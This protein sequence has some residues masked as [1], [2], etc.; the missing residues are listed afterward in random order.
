M[1]TRA[2]CALVPHRGDYRHAE[3]NSDA[4]IP[5]SL[6]GCDQMII[7][8]GG[9]GQPGTWQKIYFCEFDGPRP[10]RLWAR[11]LSA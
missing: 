10:R 5:S 9:R 7:V 8:E 6:F 4:R 3:G 11:F 2:W 1:R